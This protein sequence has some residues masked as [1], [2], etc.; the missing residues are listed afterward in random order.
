MTV[1]KRTIQPK[2]RNHDRA[3]MLEQ[4]RL[5]GEK[6]AAAASRERRI[7]TDSLARTCDTPTRETGNAR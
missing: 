3:Y 7:E 2:A 4:W 1:S 5:A 6:I